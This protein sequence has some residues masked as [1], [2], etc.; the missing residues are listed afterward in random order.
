[1]PTTPHLDLIPDPGT[2]LTPADRRRAALTACTYAVDAAEAHD[3][4]E[5]LGLLAD[6]RDR[7]LAG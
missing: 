2:G 7:R 4:L 5:A 3:F 1:M 6:L